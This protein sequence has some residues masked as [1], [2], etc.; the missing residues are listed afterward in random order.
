MADNDPSLDVTAPPQR[1]TPGRAPSD[2]RAGFTAG[3]ILAERYRI[4]GL[5]G[6]GGMGEVYRA[7]DLTLNQ[8]VALKFLPAAVDRNP[9]QL[10]RLRAEVR[11]ARQVSHPN[12]CRV[13][14]IGSVSGRSFLTMEYVDGEDL[15]SLLR[16]I[17][18]LPS[19]K[20]LEIA[21]QLCAGLAAAHDRGVIQRDLKPANVM[22]DGRGKVRI[23]DFGLAVVF[24]QGI[25]PKDWAGTPAYMA[26]EQL[27]G[28]ALT[29]Q[30]DVYA[31]GLVLYEIFTGRRLLDK[32]SI[33]E[34]KRMQTDSEALHASASDVN[35]DPAVERVIL[36]CV[37]H[38]A[39]RR[40]ESALAV[41]AALPGSDPLAAALAAGETPS[42]ML[43]AAAGDDTT[44]SLPIAIAV[45]TV[46][47]LGVMADAVWSANHSAFT[48]LQPPY[49]EE[50][51]GVKARET[52]ARLGYDT[53]DATSAAGFDI[54]QAYLRYVEQD[55]PARARWAR[56]RG[57]KPPAVFFWQRTSPVPLTPARLPGGTRVTEVDPPR[58]VPGMTLLET[59]L[60]GRLARLE[61]RPASTDQRAG[62]GPAPWPSLFREAGLDFTKFTG[63]VPQRLPPM[64]GDARGAWTGPSPDDP[65][66]PIKVEAA[67]YRGRPVFFVI[68]GPWT[69]QPGAPPAPPGAAQRIVGGV[70]LAILAALIV[71]AVLMARFNITSGRADRR[72]AARLAVFTGVTQF[73]ASLLVMAHVSS[74]GEVALASNAFIWPMIVAALAWILYVALEPYVRRTWPT[75]LI[76]WN[77]LIEG[78]V[79]DAR[80][81]RDVLI[82]VCATAWLNAADV[83]Q[84]VGGFAPTP[85]GLT[86]DRWM[87]AASLREAL[88]SVVG[89]VNFVVFLALALVFLFCLLRMVVR[90]EWIAVSI[91]AIVFAAM[92]AATAP[93]LGVNPAVGAVVFAILPTL[94]MFVLV[95]FGLVAAIAHLFS[96]VLTTTVTLNPSLWYS[97]PS[98][99]NLSIVMLFAVY[100]FTMWR[101]A[102]R[103]EIADFRRQ[104][105][106]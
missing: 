83:F 106:D 95:K 10:E 82:G 17:G 62:D 92:G 47:L 52:L 46:S 84:G 77:R 74:A 65:A 68:A 36:R 72:G 48:R 70:T 58:L 89:N 39:S 28:R 41:A 3:E 69:P 98:F 85:V 16:R 49:S 19:D 11:I 43:V 54:D 7:E 73:V 80:V 12:V 33:D 97:T 59:D 4:I 105:S 81:G 2:S 34:I 56:M 71:T 88:G 40:P 63:T 79:R 44:V 100:G 31:L 9:V 50:V 13:Y 93:R 45:L 21:R 37:E 20:G 96:S 57:L 87:A 86:P 23:M 8:P 94:L 38:D 6:R 99:L 64:W 30:T 15:A 32:R 78:R 90:R 61:V 14:D 55:R 75:A 102:R 24:E 103:I 25:D 5:L 22:L 27:G 104:I 76:S 26:P 66:V 67:A 51:L 53:P 101:S 35:L 18:H 1:A 29:P 42:P 91:L 60:D